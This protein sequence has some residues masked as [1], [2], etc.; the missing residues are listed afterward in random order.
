MA[1]TPTVDVTDCRKE[2]L[3]EGISSA[4]YLETCMS[5]RYLLS[6]AV[7]IVPLTIWAEEKP[8][9]QADPKVLRQLVDQL[10]SDDFD[11]RE[12]ACKRL[13]ELDEAALPALKEGAK[14]NDAELRQKAEELAAT[15]AARV[16]ERTI[17]KMF[18][19]IE[20]G[21]LEKF[22]DRLA[23][24]KDFGTEER[25]QLVRTIGTAIEKRATVVADRPFR[26]V[27]LDVAKMETLRAMP[28][29]AA[30]MAR[31][32]LNNDTSNVREGLFNCILVSNGSV[33]RLEKLNNCIVIVNGDIEGATVMRNCVVLCRGSIGRTRQIDT[34]VVLA[35]GNVSSADTIHASLI[36]VG[37]VGRCVKS[38]NNVYL[39]M[40]Q[41]PGFNS[42]DDQCRETKRGPLGMF[43]WTAGETSPEKK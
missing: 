27:T 10:G 23:K 20:R 17:Q 7:L 40:A 19:E 22:I 36:E 24:D 2:N 38:I 37:S 3:A 5:R 32:V 9:T 39:N 29:K 1:A 21:G 34:S 31:I 6:L 41:S 43:R 4:F 28:D 16:E 26:V 8:K 13:L 14:S 25:W 30:N 18:A 35:A 12:R 42:T 11:A 15:I 33:G